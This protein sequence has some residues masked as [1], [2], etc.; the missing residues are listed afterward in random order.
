MAQMPAGLRAT[1][2]FPKAQSPITNSISGA[3][4]TLVSDAVSRE[5]KSVV[6]RFMC[7]TPVV[8]SADDTTNATAA[9]HS[10][11]RFQIDNV[12]DCFA[13]REAAGL[14]Y[15][16]VADRIINGCGRLPA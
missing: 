13:Q 10:G 2:T 16:P 7:P 5:T 3:A 1:R 11:P 15:E 4:P 12:V 6:I 14:A 8:C 9:A